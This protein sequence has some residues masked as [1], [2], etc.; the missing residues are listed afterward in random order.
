M[1]INLNVGIVGF[2]GAGIAQFGHFQSM[3]DCR[4]TAVYDSKPGGVDRARSIAPGIL[5][6]DDFQKFIASGI[7][8]VAI[9]SSDAS[10]AEYVIAAI[11]AGLHVICEKPL[12]DSPESCQQILRA[13]ASAPGVVVAVQHQMRFLPVHR[14]I[15]KLIQSGRLGRI[16]YIEGYYV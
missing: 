5:A 15:K 8:S 7:N 1:S 10:H 16:G 9:C 11:N 6:T 3:R 12:T 4:V 13:E 2:G 14:E